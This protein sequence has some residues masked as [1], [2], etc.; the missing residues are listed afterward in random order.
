MGII[1]WRF[2]ALVPEAYVGSNSKTRTFCMKFFTIARQCSLALQVALIAIPSVAVSDIFD[3]QNSYLLEDLPD[4]A[5][6][7]EK[8]YFKKVVVDSGYK[9][10]ED[11]ISSL[12]MGEWKT[13]NGFY[14]SGATELA[15]KYFNSADLGLGR[16]MHCLDQEKIL[17]ERG[18]GAMACYVSN[19]GKIGGNAKDG[20]SGLYNPNDTEFATVAMEYRPTAVENKV[21]FFVFLSNSDPDATSSDGEDGKLVYLAGKNNSA[22]LIELD[23]GDGHSQPGLCLSCHGG[24]ISDSGVITGAHFLPFD[25]FSFEFPSSYIRDQEGKVFFEMNKLVLKA[26]ETAYASS[27]NESEKQIIKYL[28]GSLTETSLK[29]DYIEG[30]FNSNA[31]DRALYEEVVKPFCRGCHLASSVVLTPGLVGLYGNGCAK[32]AFFDSMPHAEVNERNVLRHMHFVKNFVEERS[33]SNIECNQPVLIDFDNAKDLSVARWNY[34]KGIPSQESNSKLEV[35]EVTDESL[36]GV[37]KKKR[38]YTLKQGVTNGE[39]ILGTIRFTEQD[40]REEG[41]GEYDKLKFRYRISAGAEIRLYSYGFKDG[42]FSGRFE[43]IT[44]NTTI[45]DSRYEVFDSSDTSLNDLDI[46]TGYDFILDK[47]DPSDVIELDDITFEHKPD[48]GVAAVFAD[49]ENGRVDDLTLKQAG[50]GIVSAVPECAQHRNSKGLNS[51]MLVSNSIKVAYDAGRYSFA[52]NPVLCVGETLEQTIVLNDVDKSS[53]MAYIEFDF[54]VERYAKPE[55]TMLDRTG[56]VIRKVGLVQLAVE[57][58]SSVSDS[59][60]FT[61]S[62]HIKLELPTGRDQ[63]AEIKFTMEANSFAGHSV[64]RNGEVKGQAAGF[65][66][67]NLTVIYR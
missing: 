36:V 29:D 38:V 52:S 65:A 8:A 42:Q 1:V 57:Q 33:G 17:P 61:S 41:T 11:Q 16:D 20:F 56:R 27:Q 4:D 5:L 53:A 21:R 39:F 23:N 30:A 2:L 7:V 26:E 54:I 37:N 10:T 66:I 47:V 35:I 64:V 46:V 19:H 59:I 62:G 58:R 48:N 15:A 22:S 25:T 14:N 40:F 31:N 63:P 24:E 18:A 55:I 49:F 51:G 45:A 43:S 32:G 67:D 60:S 12:T 13:F 44:S 34:R 6:A 28:E 9:S 50:S 3:P